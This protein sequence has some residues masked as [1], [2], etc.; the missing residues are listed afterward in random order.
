MGSSCRTGVLL[1]AAWLVGCAPA[2]EPKPETADALQPLTTVE[3]RERAAGDGLARSTGVAQGSLPLAPAMVLDASQLV[4]SDGASELPAEGLVPASFEPLSRWPDGSVRWVQLTT[5]VDLPAGGTTQLTVSRS[6]KPGAGTPYSFAPIELP[7]MSLRVVRSSGVETIAVEQGNLV[8]RDGLQAR[9]WIEPLGAKRTRLRSWIAQ[10]ERDDG[11]HSLSLEIASTSPAELDPVWGAFHDAERAVAV[12]L[13]HE[14]ERGP[15]SFVQQPGAVEVVLW[16][17]QERPYPA[18][19]GFHVSHSFVIEAGANGTEL[20]QRVDAPLR[21]RLDSGYVASTGAAGDLGQADAA[22]DEAIAIS[23]ARLRKEQQSAENR[24]WVAYGDFAVKN[25]NLSYLGYYNQEYDPASVLFQYYLRTGDEAAL[26]FGLEMA[27]QYADASVSLSGGSFQHR[28]TQHRI[29]MTVAL[30]VA[31][32]VRKQWRGETPDQP[33]S[34]EKMIAWSKEPLIDKGE[35][36]QALL[37]EHAS[38]SQAERERRASEYIGYCAAEQSL[39]ELEAKQGDGEMAK[40]MNQVD[41]GALE[42]MMKGEPLHRDYALLYWAGSAVQYTSPPSL[43]ETFAPLFER[44]GGSFEQMP[45]VFF[46]NTPPH[47]RRHSGGHTLS[48]MLVWGHVLS[49]DPIL[50]DFALR[51]ARHHVD[52]TLLEHAVTR[53]TEQRRQQ[54]CQREGAL[55]RLAAD[56]HA[57]SRAAHRRR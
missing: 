4:L 52:S 10:T 20:A 5:P 36:I 27:R 8:E 17:S 55:A 56:Q 7:S 32:W 47:D 37:A 13:G 9:F 33:A 53:V 14:L 3:V 54:D 40:L 39:Y 24:G 45:R 12:E 57:R 23:M 16:Q 30:P 15:I 51:S 18:D 42:R 1:I 43:E 28:A 11:W 34:D 22:V 29:I 26:D 2:D 25:G 50:K 6:D 41:P 46:T 44:Y 21:L 49:G 19:E 31:A 48:E 38:V 35:E